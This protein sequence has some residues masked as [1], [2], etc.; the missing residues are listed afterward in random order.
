MKLIICGDS[1]T[2]ALVWAR[3]NIAKDSPNTV[4]HVS[5][6]PFGN[7]RYLGL[8]FF[9][10]DGD[11][12][13]FD[14]EDYAANYELLSGGPLRRR[15]DVVHGFSMGFHTAPLFRHPMW[16]THLPWRLCQGNDAVPV[17]DATLIAM[18]DHIWRYMRAFYETAIRLKIEFFV[19]AAPPPRRSHICIQQGTASQTVLEV[20]R[21]FRESVANWLTAR[22]IEYVLPPPVVVDPEGFLLPQFEPL[23]IARDYHHG[24]GAY[25]IA[26]LREI[27]A[28]QGP[29]RIG[30]R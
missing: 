25:G 14:R 2:E 28:K 12:I 13:K 24:N 26:M 3:A 1:H 22:G 5:V 18:A 30:P 21:V 8:P 16:R 11:A 20:D 9:T 17:S 4:E 23:E 27:L 15:D 7:G 6:G 10:E 19:V 29:C